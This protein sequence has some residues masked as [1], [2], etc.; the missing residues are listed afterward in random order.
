MKENQLDPQKALNP[1]YKKFTPLK[2][3]VDEFTK[4]L[5]KCIAAINLMDSKA[6]S[7]EHL[8]S[9]ITKFL[10][11]TFYKDNEINTRERIDLAIYLG[12]DASSDVG[13]LLEA[14]KPSNKSEFPKKD[15]LNC[16]A[17][18]E[19]LL[20]YLKE[21][22]D[23]KNNNIKHLVITNGFEC[24]FFKAEDFYDTFYKNKELVKE[25][26]QFRDKLK[27]SSRNELFYDE[28]AKKY[29]A[30]IQD[31]IPFVHLDFRNKN[32]SDFKQKEIVNIY[33][34]FSDVHLLGESLVMI[35]IN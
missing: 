31:E 21:R 16:K 9:P 17:F 19:L 27:D 1:A 33:K 34:L 5:E 15:N 30:K 29:I 32:I 26:G 20:Y 14:K 3:D 13:V 4:E 12:K 22:I 18:Q 24:Y 8:K 23:Y 2:K 35:A 11:S 25:Y 6:E 28:I 7:E 10:S